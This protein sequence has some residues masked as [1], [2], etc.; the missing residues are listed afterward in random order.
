MFYKWIGWQIEASINSKVLIVG[1]DRKPLL[2]AFINAYPV[3][4][5]EYSNVS[6][7]H[8]DFWWAGKS[9]KEHNWKKKQYFGRAPSAIIE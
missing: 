2:S 9:K 1:C 8:N 7:L 3:S 4:T 5:V 6:T